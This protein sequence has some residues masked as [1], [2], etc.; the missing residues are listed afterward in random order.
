M[1]AAKLTV[2][3]RVQG[4]GYRNYIDTKASHL[5]LKGYVKN[6]PNGDVEIW[7][8]G[9]ESEILEMIDMSRRGSLFSKVNNLHVDWSEPTYTFERFQITD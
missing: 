1:K 8:E 7:V 6:M 2:S 3:G 4:V 5:N 9:F